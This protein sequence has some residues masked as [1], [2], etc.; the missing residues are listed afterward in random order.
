MRFLSVLFAFLIAPTIS[1]ADVRVIDG[2]TIELNGKVH[3]INGIDAP[4]H[5]QKCETS[6]GKS[7]ACG[8]EATAAMAELIE[9]QK[10]TCEA[11]GADDYERSI[12][13]CYVNGM[14]IGARLVEQGW[15]WAFVRYSDIYVEQE[16]RARAAKAAIW[17]G[18]AI[19]AWEY[20]AKRWEQ[21]VDQVP[22]QAPEGCP[23]KG[24][25]SQNGR[26]Y[27]APWSPWY[28]RTKI[29]VAKG[30]RW[31]CDEAEALAAGWRAPYWH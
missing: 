7:W 2:D 1:F 9:G 18:K 4:E 22:S 8:K 29:N 28:S 15:A 13:T 5:G 25:I 11:F 30:E 19:P 21:A 14:D 17:Q 20:R 16:E 3:R 12:S 10:V 26:I 27:H 24:N 31:F 6:Y 23:I